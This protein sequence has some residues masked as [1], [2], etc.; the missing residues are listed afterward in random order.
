[1]IF[2]LPLDSGVENVDDAGN[3]GD[4]IIPVIYRLEVVSTARYGGDSYAYELNGE[5]ADKRNSG[6]LKDTFHRS[7]NNPFEPAGN[8]LKVDAILLYEP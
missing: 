2:R 8:S 4:T 5:L 6:L 3:V 1:M 7:P